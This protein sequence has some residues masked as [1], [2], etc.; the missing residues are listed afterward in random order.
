MQNAF[1]LDHANPPLQRRYTSTRGKFSIDSL[2]KIS[3]T[4]NPTDRGRN[5]L[6]NRRTI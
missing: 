3:R 1:G 2:E 4:F 6:P 5:I